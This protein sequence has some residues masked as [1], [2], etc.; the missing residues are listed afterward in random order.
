MTQ[1]SGYSHLHSANSIPLYTR[2]TIADHRARL[3]RISTGIGAQRT[4]H[5][6]KLRARAMRVG[7]SRHIA[8]LSSHRLPLQAQPGVTPIR[9]YLLSPRPYPV[10]RLNSKQREYTQHPGPSTQTPPPSNQAPCR[11]LLVPSRTIVES[12]RTT[13]PRKKIKLDTAQT[14]LPAHLATPTRGATSLDHKTTPTV[15][16]TTPTHLD[17]DEEP[18]EEA[19]QVEPPAPTPEPPQSQQ[20]DAAI[21]AGGGGARAWGCGRGHSTSEESESS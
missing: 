21:R 9:T 17:H 14:T 19:V 5:L 1:T 2:R 16:I 11:R 7:R 8:L 13:D 15:A 6:A 3:L 10:S 18:A 4:L 12:H 20:R